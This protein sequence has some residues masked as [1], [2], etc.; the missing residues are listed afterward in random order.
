[1]ALQRTTIKGFGQVELNNVAF[2][3][4]G[5]IEAQCRLSED[6]ATVPAENGMILS[7]NKDKG[8]VG[9][10]TPQSLMFALNYSAEHLY[11]QR[12]KS[13]K[14]FRLT[15]G[16]VYPRL[17]Y[18]VDGDRFT[19]NCL[20]FDTEEFE[21]E[22]KALKKAIYGGISSVGAILIS[23]TAP[24]E[25]PVLLVVKVTDMPDGQIGI[26]FQVVDYVTPDTTAPTFKGITPAE[27]AVELAHDENFVLTVKAS[28]ENLYELEVD[29]SLEAS[30]PEF[31]VYASATDPYG[32]AEDAAAFAAAGVVVTYDA[33]A[34]EWTIDFGEAVTNAI[35]ANEGVTFYLVIK[36]EAGNEWGSMYDVTEDNTFAYTVSR[37]PAPGDSGE[38]GDGNGNENPDP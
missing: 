10:P 36:D 25:G 22:T 1:M 33:D 29:H 16:E 24:T 11:D 12:D 32:S 21:D 6:F 37:L 2:R 9:L 4:N 30:L 18:L 13:L 27:G 31:S 8:E 5:S 17:G 20:V 15:P 23:E 14:S 34:Q 19:T 3:R 28:D 38:P 7:V 35:V 26:K